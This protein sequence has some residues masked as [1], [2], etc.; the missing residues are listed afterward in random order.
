MGDH[1]QNESFEAFR[2]SLS[3]GSRNDLNFKFFKGMS[4][5]QVASFLQDLLHKLGDA[6]DTGD[7]LPLIEAAYE[8]QAEGYSPEPDAPPPRNSFEV[9]PFTPLEKAIA[10][11]TVGMLT[12]SGHFV[13]GDDPMPFG[14]ASLTQEDAVNRINEFL[15]EIPLLSEIPS[16]TPTSDLRVRHGGYDI[17][18]A[19]RDPNVTFPIDRLREVQARG[20][21]RRLASTFFSFPGATSQGRLRS[22]LPGWVERIHEEEIDVMLLV[23]V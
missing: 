20:G 23:P 5:E 7:V 14:E 11:S 15:R 4:D 19:V 12:T 18:S 3:Y 2:K 13:A 17:R 21:V 6:Y 10:N 1:E 22:E 9:G 16:D 8:A